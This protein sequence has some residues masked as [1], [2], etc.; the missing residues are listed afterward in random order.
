MAFKVTLVDKQDEEHVEADRYEDDGMWINFTKTETAEGVIGV[1]E[2]QIL[3]LRAQ[4][5]IRIKRID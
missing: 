2:K 1:F 3:R 4:D 5:V